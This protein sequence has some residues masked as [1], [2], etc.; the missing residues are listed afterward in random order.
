MGDRYPVNPDADSDDSSISVSSS[1]RSQLAVE[2]GTQ[3]TRR[4]TTDSDRNLHISITKAPGLEA[5]AGI[6]TR[7]VD[8]TVTAGTLTTIATHT[9]VTNTLYLDNVMGDGQYDGQ[10][11]LVIDNVVQASYCTSEQD[12]TAKFPFPTAHPISVGSIIDIKVN[13][14]GPGASTGSFSATIIGHERT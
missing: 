13:H 1:D 14:N 8:P 10:W 9:V 4:L 5:T 12:R 6:R 2:K 11:F 7:G 3:K